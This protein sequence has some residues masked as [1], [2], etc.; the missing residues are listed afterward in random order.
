M[1]PDDASAGQTQKIV[2]VKVYPGVNGSFDLF[3]DDGKTYGYERGH[4]SLT[5][6]TW[7]DAAHRLKH[8][9]APAWHE[10][11]AAVVTVVGGSAGN[12]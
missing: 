10:S 9:G 5:K 2:A 12:P 7:D 8:E 6:L 1:G 3:Q 4:Y 11:D